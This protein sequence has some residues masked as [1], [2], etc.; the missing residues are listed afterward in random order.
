MPR[1]SLRNRCTLADSHDMSSRGG[2]PW[3]APQQRLLLRVALGQGN[4][5][6]DAWRAWQGQVDPAALDP[7]S[8]RLLPRLYRNLTGLGIADP[9]IRCGGATCNRAWGWW[10]WAFGA[11]SQRSRDGYAVLAYRPFMMAM[12]PRDKPRSPT[13]SMSVDA[14]GSP[15]RSLPCVVG[16]MDRV[17][18]RGVRALRSTRLP[19]GRAG[20]F[21]LPRWAA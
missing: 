13:S 18:A 10:A 5:A 15:I 9:A 17:P 19:A 21:R 20:T 2:G 6:L 7:G 4:A 3:P 16:P 1:R 8:L 11:Q 12:R 14:K